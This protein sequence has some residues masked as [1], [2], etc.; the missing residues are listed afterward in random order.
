MK[1][2]RCSVTELNEYSELIGTALA[3]RPTASVGFAVAPWLVSERVSN[4]HRGEIR[5]W[6]IKTQLHDMFH[7]Y[8]CCVGI[9][10]V[11]HLLDGYLFPRIQ[12][13]F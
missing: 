6:T 13:L 11:L 5:T 2:G 10:N 7:H 4:G 3:R 9:H 8:V 12:Q 1:L